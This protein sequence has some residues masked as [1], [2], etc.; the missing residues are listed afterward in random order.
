M[1]AKEW[2]LI[3]QYIDL[4]IVYEIEDRIEDESG[5]HGNAIDERKS[6]EKAEKDIDEHLA[7]NP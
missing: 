1:N 6:V 5:Y 3:K 7:T 2:L 4:K